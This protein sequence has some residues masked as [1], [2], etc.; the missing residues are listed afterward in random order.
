MVT[1]V[2]KSFLTVEE[3]AE[4]RRAR[5]APATGYSWGAG[6]GIVAL[7]SVP[8]CGLIWVAVTSA[9]GG[10]KEWAGLMWIAAW[11]AG[12]Y[13]LFVAFVFWAGSAS[14]S[15][16]D[17]V[18]SFLWKIKYSDRVRSGIR[19][20]DPPS[21]FAQ[22]GED[23]DIKSK[24]QVDHEWYGGHSELNWRDRELGQMYGMDADTYISNVLEN[25]KD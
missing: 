15:S 12:L 20:G 13:G 10:F 4:Y 5:R 8:V 16:E 11:A 24:R 21:S 18:R 6:L 23:D 22:R 7:S 19:P 9:E 25:D 14:E 1:V 17:A 3:K 2:D